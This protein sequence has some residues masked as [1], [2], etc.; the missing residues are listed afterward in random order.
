MWSQLKQLITYEEQL[1]RGGNSLPPSSPL[2]PPSPECPRMGFHIPIVLAEPGLETPS[3]S[4]W[5]RIILW[6]G[7][8]IHELVLPASCL[9]RFLLVPNYYVLSASCVLPS[10]F[11]NSFML[12]F[13]PSP[14]SS[15]LSP[16]MV[17]N[18]SIR[19]AGLPPCF[20]KAALALDGKTGVS[21]HPSWAN[22]S[23][24]ALP[25]PR[26]PVNHHQLTLLWITAWSSMATSSPLVILLPRHQEGDGCGPAFPFSYFSCTFSFPNTIKFGSMTDEYSL[27]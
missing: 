2:F 24:S 14:G 26:F 11:R 15:L 20:A 3:P 25:P 7:H 21:R 5:L 23:A 22:H 13:L 10:L 1:E 17:C 12:F 9:M 27:S 8:S 4:P 19:P 6:D 18:P 16:T